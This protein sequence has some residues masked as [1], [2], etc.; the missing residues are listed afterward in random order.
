MPTLSVSCARLVLQ[1]VNCVEAPSSKLTQ[2]CAQI[3]RTLSEGSRLDLDEA[4]KLIVQI[5]DETGSADAGA[6]A[7]DYF[8]PGQYD[9]QLYAIM[10]SA[11]LGEA[12]K[13]MARYSVLLSDGAPQALVEGEH[14]VGF[15]FLC[16]DSLGVPRQYI[17]CCMSIF[18]AMVHW[19]EPEHRPM[20]LRAAFSYPEPADRSRLEAVFGP[21]L[22]F[23]SP[24]NK[25]IF[26]LADCAR[27]LETANPTLRLYHLNFSDEE[28]F[29]SQQR[30][31]AMVK[32]LV[33][34][35]LTTGKGVMSL[36]Q[37]A[38]ELNLS[39]RTLQN[40]LD[41]EASGFQLIVDEC[42][43]DLAR[44]LLHS[45]TDTITAISEKLGF[46]DH[47]AFHK[48]FNRWYACTPGAFR[49]G[50]AAS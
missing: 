45:T 23:S 25:V 8:R 2:L 15:H 7:Y 3:D 29:K 22:S 4:L 14:E 44:Q 50:Q 43:R 21:H 49:N 37:V 20:P 13:T 32:N 16:L 1:L 34:I 28:L 10:S 24:V 18:M 19:L 42:R 31:S 35:G 48:A 17:D 11:T 30:V 33:L 41:D 26:S 39:M 46:C 6:S 47:S 5:T 9:S 27:P 36:E 40:R 38:R 12:L